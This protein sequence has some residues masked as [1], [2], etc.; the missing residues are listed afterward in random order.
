MFQIQSKKKQV[1]RWFNKTSEYW[2]LRTGYC[3]VLSTALCL[4]G[5]MG[6]Y[7]GGFECPAGRGVGCKSISDVNQMVNQGD[8]PEKTGSDLSPSQSPCEQCGSNRDQ[9]IDPQHPSKSEIW[10]P[11]RVLEE[12]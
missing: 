6:I 4:S 7:E 10:Y 8:L 9:P 1:F 2:T 12:V 3:A 11:T 5:C